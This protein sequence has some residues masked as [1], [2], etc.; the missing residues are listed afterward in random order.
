MPDADNAAQLVAIDWGTTNARSYLLAGSTTGP[1]VLDQRTGQGILAVPADAPD[2]D[3]RF[4]AILD[5]LVAPWLDAHPDLPMIACGMVGAAQG[6][7]AA[8]YR[9]LPT[10]LAS[11]AGLA[12]VQTARG[13]LP[14]IAGVRKSRPNADVMRGEETQ[15]AGLTDEFARGETALVVMPGTHTKWAVVRDDTL[16]DFDTAMSGEIY[17]LLADHSMVGRVA[18][19]GEPQQDWRAGFDWGL[20]LAAA[21]RALAF[22][23]FVIRS[24]VL[25]GQLPADQVPDA[26]SGLL[27]GAEVADKVDAIGPHLQPVRLVGGPALV[28]RYAH[29]LAAYGVDT[30]PAA[31]DV[32][33]RGLWR[34]AIGAG[35]VPG[36]S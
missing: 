11:G 23:A 30:T 25:D 9:T 22:S 2:R 7:R 29:A 36:S 26:I 31:A 19:P 6:W 1:V 5:G 35:L 14:I 12:I 4:E 20:R 16:L 33:V 21:R 28:E 15:L 27:I 10:T 34:T 17:S 13:L 8:P 18:E 32:T 24:S 3:D